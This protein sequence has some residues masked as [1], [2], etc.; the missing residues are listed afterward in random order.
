MLELRLFRCTGLES[1]KIHTGRSQHRIVNTILITIKFPLLEQELSPPSQTQGGF[2]K[3][4]PQFIGLSRG[5]DLGGDWGDGP[6]QN[7]RWGERPMHW[8]PQYFEKQCCRMC[9]KV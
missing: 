5:G 3:V 8:S 4:K 7:L 9:M 6:P 2:T 1:K